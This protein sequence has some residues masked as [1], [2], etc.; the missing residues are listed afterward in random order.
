MQRL[1]SVRSL[2][3]SFYWVLLNRSIKN[4]MW[5]TMKVIITL[6]FQLLWISFWILYWWYIYE[7][8]NAITKIWQAA[9]EILWYSLNEFHL[10]FALYNRYFEELVVVQ[11]RKKHRSAALKKFWR[12]GWHSWFKWNK[13]GKN[14]LK[15]CTPNV[16]FDFSEFFCWWRLNE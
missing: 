11:F 1:S 15:S 16:S 14:V 3:C 5:K 4:F 2:E 6:M 12:N 7:T 9:Q 13:I 8:Q 10:I